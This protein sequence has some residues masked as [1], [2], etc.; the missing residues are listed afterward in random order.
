MKLFCGLVLSLAF[1]TA[2][3]NPQLRQ[4]NTVYI[5]AMTAGMDQ[6]LANQLTQAGVFQVVTDPQKAD[7]ILTDRLGEPFENKLSELYPPPPP[8]V[9][10]EAAATDDKKASG[11]LGGGGAVRVVSSF[12]RTKGN[13]FVVDRRSRAVLW[14]VYVQPKDS[15]P[16]ELTKTAG[17]IVKLL[18]EDVSG[19]KT[20]E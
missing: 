16:G 12:N 17:K 2:A 7:A 8:P 4:V 20:V 11:D 13:F 5:L 14:S 1:M 3:V 15:T 10:K 19:K 18:R 9:K 6:F